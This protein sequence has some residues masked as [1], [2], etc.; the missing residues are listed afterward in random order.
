MVVSEDIFFFW[1]GDLVGVW[2]IVVKEG[3]VERRGMGVGGMGFIVGWG[4]QGG[5]EG[6]GVYVR[7]DI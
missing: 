3:F 4:S 2:E 6:S 7:S 5:G 1:C